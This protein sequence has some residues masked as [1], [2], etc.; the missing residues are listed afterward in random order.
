[1]SI[2]YTVQKNGNL[3]YA[4]AGSTLSADDIIKLENSIISDENIKPGYN[5]LLDWTQV[6]RLD[7]VKDEVDE[8]VDILIKDQKS[9]PV[10]KIAI[11]ARPVIATQLSRMVDAASERVNKNVKLIFFNDISTAEMWLGIK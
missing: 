7:M 10:R 1:M 2:N 8:I 5:S 3:L 9:L 11:V 4:D 6:S